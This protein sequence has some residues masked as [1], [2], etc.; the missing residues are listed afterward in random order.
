MMALISPK[1]L[2]VGGAAMLAA[3]RRNHQKVKVG[4][5]VWVPFIK[6]NLRELTRE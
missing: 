2:R 6:E 5:K 3:A 1:R 4:A